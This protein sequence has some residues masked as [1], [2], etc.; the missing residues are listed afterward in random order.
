VAQSPPCHRLSPSQSPGTLA[1]FGTDLRHGRN[2]DL[3]VTIAVALAVAVLGVSGFVDTEVVGAATLAVLAVLA[4]SGLTGRH[5]IEEV[6]TAVDRLV[7]SEAGDIPAEKFLAPR[8]ADLDSEVA[9]A[10]DIRLVGVTLTRTV[11]DLLP[12]CS[13][14][15]S[16][17]R[18][19]Q[20]LPSSAMPAGQLGAAGIGPAGRRLQ[21]CGADSRTAPRR[22]EHGRLCRPVVHPPD[23]CGKATS[24]SGS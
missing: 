22:H 21:S 24:V 23:G 10:I 2:L 7:A 1:R 9:S 17:S 16:M 8:H 12:G 5:H 18:Q 11:R 6:R 19:D 20:L 4:T 3:Y 15:Q 14:A 13:R